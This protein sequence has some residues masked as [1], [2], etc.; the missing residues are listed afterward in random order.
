MADDK[1][2]SGALWRVLILLAFSLFINYV[3]RGNL[4]IAAPLLK[5]EFHL[6]ASQLGILFS[7]FFWTYA[8]FLV[9][10]GWLVDRFHAGWLLAAG[11]FL[12]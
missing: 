6:S 2:L 10:S 3:D 12:W 11:F 5:Q 8:S 4:S 7:A 1:R 9:V